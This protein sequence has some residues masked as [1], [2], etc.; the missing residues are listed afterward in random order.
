VFPRSYEVVVP[1]VSCCITDLEPARLEAFAALL[2]RALEILG[3]LPLD[4]EIHD[5][6]S[7]P[8]HAH[9]NARHYPYSNIGGTLNLPANI[10]GTFRRD[11][12]T[13]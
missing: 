2:Y 1:D 9:V 5:G 8:L 11:R 6:P 10:L 13:G 12:S 3:P 7:V 4:Y